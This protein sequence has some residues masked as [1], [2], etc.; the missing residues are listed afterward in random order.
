M[1]RETEELEAMEA[2]TLIDKISDTLHEFLSAWRNDSY[3]W[4]PE[5]TLWEIDELIENHK[6]KRI[7]IFDH[8]LNRVEVRNGK[9]TA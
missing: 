3:P 5:K 4:P 8:S 7:L 1:G 9:A 6:S 2:E